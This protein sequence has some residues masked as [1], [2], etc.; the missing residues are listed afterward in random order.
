MAKKKIL[1]DYSYHYDL[2]WYFNATNIPNQE[3]VFATKNFIEQYR[4]EEI[5]AVQFFN[6]LFYQKEAIKEYLHKPFDYLNRLDAIRLSETLRHTLYGMLLY[7]HG[8]NPEMLL[9]DGPVTMN[10]K[11]ILRL[12]NEKFWQQFPN[13]DTPEKL[14]CTNEP[15]RKKLTHLAMELNDRL[16]PKSDDVDGQISR[17]VLTAAEKAEKRIE[18]QAEFPSSRYIAKVDVN[19]EGLPTYVI[20]RGIIHIWEAE[21]FRSQ[22]DYKKWEQSLEEFLNTVGPEYRLLTLQKGIEYGQKCYDQ[23]LMTECD[24]ISSCSYN[25][26]WD[27][28]K[29]IAQRML[30]RLQEPL[31]QDDVTQPE[32]ERKNPEFTTARQVLALHYIFEHLQVRGTEID[33]AAKERFAHFLT[34]KSQQNIHAAFTDPH[35][36]PKTKNFRF[37]DLQYIRKYF[38]DLGLAEIVKS[39]NNQLEKPR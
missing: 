22:D 24:D 7:W 19:F 20:R 6:L 8:G 33:K 4:S 28:R 26:S 11:T 14:F 29:V 32:M 10:Y 1:A 25:E 5:T 38:E 27:R 17:K 30:E 37:E 34:G 2:N 12:V 9:E 36:Q 18:L 16:N 23:H 3:L 31:A 35:L 15:K 39:I 13:V 21:T